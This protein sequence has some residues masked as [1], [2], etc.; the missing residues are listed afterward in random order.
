MT[1]LA[2]QETTATIGD[3]VIAEIDGLRD[4][5]VGLSH[6]IHGFAELSFEEHRAAAV[7]ADELAAAGFDVERG[8]AGLPTAFKASYGTGDLVVGICAEYDAL[9]DVGHACGHNI[10]ATTALG[11]GL[12]LAKVADRL[13]LTVKVLG[14]PA[15]EHGGGKVLMID[16]GLFDDLTLA[17]M[18]HPGNA[19]THPADTATQGVSR[20][21][22][23]FSGKASHAAAAPQLGVNAADAAVVTQVALGLLRQQ[24]PAT[25]RVA[26]F[27]REG[28]QATNIIPERTVVDFE[29]RE[30]DLEAQRNLHARVLA[31]FEAGAL[32]T[33]CTLELE[34]TEPEYAPLQQD[35]RIGDRYADALD[36]VG[37][38]IAQ[39]SPLSGGSTDMG[40]VSQLLPS[41]H[42]MIA[43][44]GSENPPHTHGFARDAVSAEADATVVDGATAMALTAVSVAQ[45]EALRGELLAE[46]RERAAT[47]P[48]RSR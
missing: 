20:W 21:A 5:L 46:Q 25:A 4:R 45:D 28:G 33:G 13:G 12:A 2:D 47:T 3:A 26:A 9:P 6:D 42:P 37:R 27:V 43:V 29:V 34:E 7:L 11:A 8:V 16:A 32:A 24:L 48:N 23:T 22:A 35:A 44:R 38:P 40:N 39:R 17:M 36:R 30:F 31:C 18:V 15:E 41:I 10:I 14:T 19:D 1:T